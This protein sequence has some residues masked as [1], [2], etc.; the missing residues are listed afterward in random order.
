MALPLAFS[1][2][3][4]LAATLHAAQQGDAPPASERGLRGAAV[5]GRGTPSVDPEDCAPG[6]RPETGLQGQIP[7]EDQL[8]GRSRLGYRCNV[9]LVGQN[10]IRHRGVNF[11]MAAYRDCAYVG[12]SNQI[13][14]A[15]GTPDERDHPL[16]GIAVIDAENPRDPRLVRFLKSPVGQHQ[17]EAM[18]VNER[19]GMLVV[20]VGGLEAQW[21]EIYDIS[22]DCTKPKFMS[23]YDSGQPQ[24]HGLEIS[25][26]GRTVYASNTFPDAPN[27]KALHV[28]DVTDMARPR[29]I[30]TWDPTE[31]VPPNDY[32]IH[33]LGVNKSGTRA[34]LGAVQQLGTLP[35]PRTPTVVVLD[36]SDIQARA[37]NPDLRVVSIV[38]SQNFGHEVIPAT[39]DDKPYLVSGGEL[40]L[41]GPQYCP[42]AWGNLIDIS[43]ESSPQVVSTLQLE[44]NELRNCPET[45]QDQGGYSIHY[46]GV[47][48][49]S[50][51]KKV[52]F[53]WY[54]SGLRI[55]DVRNP[56]RPR[57]I[58]YYISPPKE[59]TVFEPAFPSTGVDQNRRWD[60]STSVVRY[61]KKTGH[62]WFVS[63]ANGFQ[64]VKLVE[65]A[66]DRPGRDGGGGD[67]GDDDGGGA[68]RSARGGGTDPEDSV[69]RV[70]AAPQESRPSGVGGAADGGGGD[71]PFTG[72]AL[73][74]IA[75]AGAV[76]VGGGLAFR[77]LGRRS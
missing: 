58:G 52:F 71:L 59:D 16:A 47:D 7:L 65:Q 46:G 9:K 75:L 72:L 61:R 12:T 28:I 34:Y 39:I 29:L 73:A 6:A 26:D 77:T 15:P 53:T 17:H 43:N 37:P 66:G 70:A 13:F 11:Q 18:E 48:D 23:R 14:Q 45:T 24:Y 60:Q 10:D 50:D 31:E 22:D 38:R 57:E 41:N 30:T 40:P 32:G 62:I 44:V 42:W 33:D 25:S 51:T 67:R 35:N 5:D 68:D 49:A 64:I 8:S 55:F 69:Q 21:I 54:M 20:Q 56:A 76:L 4:L 63:I 19:R 27:R 36:T 3:I 1:L 2:A 74:L